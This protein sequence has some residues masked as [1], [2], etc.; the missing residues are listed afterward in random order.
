MFMSCILFNFS[1]GPDAVKNSVACL[2][3]SH[4]IVLGPGLGRETD[5]MNNVEVWMYTISL[6]SFHVIEKIRP[7]KFGF[8]MYTQFLHYHPYFL[9]V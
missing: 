4:S 6:N 7:V 1:H 8:Y 9:F 2:P 3:R 5:T